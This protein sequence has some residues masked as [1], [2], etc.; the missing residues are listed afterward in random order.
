MGSIRGVRDVRREVVDTV[1]CGRR[2][3]HAL[4][5]RRGQRLSDLCEA[6]V[7]VVVRHAHDLFDEDPDD[8]SLAPLQADLL[9][10]LDHNDAPALD[11]WLFEQLGHQVRE[12]L[13]APWAPGDE[14]GRR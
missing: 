4:R 8:G 14:D 2:T 13:A 6:L 1:F 5:M 12:A 11:S 3:G 10:A 9:R 7:L